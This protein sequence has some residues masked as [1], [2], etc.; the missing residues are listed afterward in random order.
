MYYSRKLSVYNFTIY[1]VGRH[2]ALCYVWS[3]N[4]AKKG[5]NEVGSCLLHF[6]ETMAKEGVTEFWL[7]S[8]NC[9]GQNRNKNV[10]AAFLY[11][12]AK[13]NVN[14]KMT[15]LEVGHTQNEGDSV[16]AM[17][18]KYAKA[19]KVYT[20]KQWI[21]MIKNAKVT[22]PQYEV[23]EMKY[24]MFYNFVE[25]ADQLNWKKKVIRKKKITAK[26]YLV[27]VGI[28]KFKQVCVYKENNSQLKF[29][30]DFDSDFETLNTRTEKKHA[31]VKK[32][33]LNKA[34]KDE[35]GLAKAKIEDLTKL[36]NKGIIPVEHH[37]YF[38]KFKE[39]VDRDTI[40]EDAKEDDNDED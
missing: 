2:R 23:I 4:D 25:L 26:E 27:D 18:E 1:D 10:F 15:Y 28:S 8:D 12:A 16:H 35:H 24:D 11:A 37:D 40:Q 32:Y 3:E 9:G 13:L 21:E 30:L 17:I 19:Q 39:R 29:K 36:C 31:N 22:K 33:T 6:F 14:I 20:V 38:K 34:Y 5:S 7:Y